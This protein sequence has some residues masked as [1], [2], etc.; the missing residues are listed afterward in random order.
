MATKEAR[1]MSLFKPV[2]LDQ[3]VALSPTE[4]RAASA[5]IDDFL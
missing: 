5:D 4:F 3:R 1:P 2:Y